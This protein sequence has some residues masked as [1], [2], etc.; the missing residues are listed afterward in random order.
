MLVCVG[1]HA[2]L[3][4]IGPL[5]VLF[6]HS[7]FACTDANDSWLQVSPR[8]PEGV[9]T[10]AS[11]QGPLGFI[12]TCIYARVGTDLSCCPRGQLPRVALCPV[13]VGLPMRTAGVEAG[14]AATEVC[15]MFVFTCFYADPR[16]NGPLVNLIAG[17][18]RTCTD[19]NESW[20]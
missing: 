2:C 6:V 14:A 7:I 15:V 8:G 20:L 17:R 3:R 5:L 9:C 16:S 12:I 11:R 18:F 4:V 1:I 10:V 13:Y 19:G